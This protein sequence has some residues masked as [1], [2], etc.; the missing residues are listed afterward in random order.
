MCL[1]EYEGR[2]VCSTLTIQRITFK[3]Q[4]DKYNLL[5]VLLNRIIYFYETVRSFIEASDVWEVKPPNETETT[6]HFE[7]YERVNDA[8]K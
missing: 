8:P 1:D 7:D 5:F 3:H 6:V 2:S 4:F